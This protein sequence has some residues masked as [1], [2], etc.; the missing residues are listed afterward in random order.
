MATT[1]ESVTSHGLYVACIPRNLPELPLRRQFA[2][3]NCRATGEE[4]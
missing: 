3:L 4:L 1:I 2:Y